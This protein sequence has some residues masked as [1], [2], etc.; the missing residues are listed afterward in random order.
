MTE[1]IRPDEPSIDEDKI[2]RKLDANE[3]GIELM[4]EDENCNDFEVIP[5]MIGVDPIIKLLDETKFRLKLSGKD[6]KRNKRRRRRTMKKE[7]DKDNERCESLLVHEERGN[8]KELVNKLKK[9]K[10]KRKED[11][12]KEEGFGSRSMIEVIAFRGIGTEENESKGEEESVVVWSEK[13]LKFREYL[14]GKVYPEP[15][16]EIDWDDMEMDKWGSQGRRKDFK[17]K[18]KTKRKSSSGLCFENFIWCR[19]SNSWK[20]VDD[21]MTEKPKEEFNSRKKR[22]KKEETVVMVNRRNSP[23]GKKLLDLIYGGW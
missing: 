4:L 6:G 1:K 5:R 19:G 8:N 18:R 20:V 7:P 9:R 21:Y 13:G 11:N 2:E 3:T 22:K 23:V 14:K 17:K 10:K 15:E 12:C 16:E